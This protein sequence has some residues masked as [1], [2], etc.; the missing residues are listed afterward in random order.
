MERPANLIHPERRNATQA[1]RRA[2]A[3]AEV[4]KNTEGGLKKWLILGILAAGVISVAVWAL[5]SET[6][7]VQHV[8]IEGKYRTAPEVLQSLLS[9]Y[10]AAGFLY[11]DLTAMQAALMALPWIEQATVTPH[12][13]D[14]VRITLTEYEPLAIWQQTQ[15]AAP[16]LVSTQA[17]PIAVTPTAEEQARLPL[18]VGEQLSTLVQRYRQATVLFN[19]TGLQLQQLSC[20]IRQV[21]TL[22]LAEGLRIVLGRDDY[23]RHLQRFLSVY[24]RIV[25]VQDMPVRQVDLRYTNGI[26]VQLATAE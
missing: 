1:A 13:P 25:D 22:Q 23:Y 18:L 2:N 14:T 5:R 17:T 10:T 26:A 19:P 20:S 11:L 7:T 24:S 9:R 3:A 21:C 16:I 12:W 6:F 8:K 15:T 4:S